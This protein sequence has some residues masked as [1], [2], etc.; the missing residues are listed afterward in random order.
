MFFFLFAL[1]VDIVFLI[2]LEH[3]EVKRQCN[4]SLLT[5]SLSFRWMVSR[6]VGLSGINKGAKLYSHAPFILDNSIKILQFSVKSEK[7]CNQ[8]SS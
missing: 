7:V 4:G 5:N 8:N 2:I 1:L 3:V 6:S